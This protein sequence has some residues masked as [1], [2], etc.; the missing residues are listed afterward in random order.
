MDGYG[1]LKTLGKNRAGFFFHALAALFLV[2]VFLLALKPLA[3]PDL[4]WHLATGRW[5]TEN[6]ALPAEDPFSYTTGSLSEES[7][8]A[9]RAQWL[10]QVA[11]YLAYLAGGYSGLAFFRGLLIALPFVFLYASSIRK[12]V[13]PLPVLSCLAFPLFFVALTNYNT[14]E[15]PQAFSFVLA[16][17]VLALLEKTRREG[18]GP[19]MWLLPPLMLLWANLHGGYIVGVVIICAYAAGDALN[20]AARMA[21]VKAVEE[22]SPYPSAF[23]LT[24]LACVAAAGLNP[25]GYIPLKVLVRT[26]AGV[27]GM[28]GGGTGIVMAEV[29][30]YKSLWYHYK[31]LHELWPLLVACFYFFALASLAMKYV[32][33]RRLDF[34]EMLVS[35]FLLFFGLYYARGVNF[36]LILLAFFA[37]GSLAS[38]SGLKRVFP[39]LA[40]VLVFVWAAAHAAVKTPWELNPRPPRY[41]VSDVYPERAVRFLEEHEVEGPIFNALEW[42][43]YLIF[44][45]YPRYRV[46]IDGR[47]LSSRANR[48]YLEAGRAGPAWKEILDAYG[49]EVVLMPLINRINGMPTPLLYRMAGEEGG[50]WR[51]VYLRGNEAVFVRDGA[52]NRAVLDCCAMPSSRFFRKMAEVSEL[53][54]LSRPGHPEI[55]FSKA[56]ALYEL[57]AIGE[58][59]KIL[60]SLP[61]S[62]ER[63]ELLEKIASRGAPREEYR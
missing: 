56:L 47:E 26:A 46:F 34:A 17:L 3:D 9:A 13:H 16:L 62:V 2:Y 41:W 63:R 14:F 29:L 35:A 10:G 44:R 52:K 22:P 37:C 55:R 7:V 25:A 40:L 31:K 33:K 43:G 48:D 53:L 4:W 32:V 24:S 27:L 8:R 11:F 59:E 38:L 1:I 30:E 28:G 61:P 39:P 58:A 51:L 5:I 12:G 6:R 21:G 15:R 45:A 23:F 57:G 20:R 42:G 19:W 49:V 54:L 60:M 50:W 36:T 18:R